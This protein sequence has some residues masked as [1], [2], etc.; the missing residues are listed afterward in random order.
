MAGVR[1][2]R[3]TKRFGEVLAVKDFTLDIRDGE[4]IILVGPSG[5]GKT[6]VLRCIAG[7]EQ[8]TSGEIYIDG[9]PVT[10][11]PA[12]SRDIAM[13]FQNYALYPHMDVYRNMAFCLKLR[14]IP[15][16]ERDRIVRQTAELLGIGALLGRKPSELSGGQ[17][18]RVA[19]GRAIVRDPKVFLFDEPL[20]NLDA[21]LRVAMRAELLDLHQRLKTTAI[22][23]T[24]DQMEAMTMGDR[25][26]VMNE[27]LV[28]QVASPQE[29]Y[30][31]PVNRFVAGFIG[32]PAMNLV[33]CH[34]EHR[35]GG[36][37]ATNKAMSL[38]IPPGKWA[39]LG[40]YVGKEVT[41]GLRPEHVSK[42]HVLPGSASQ[43]TFTAV[44]WVV[45]PLGPEKLVHIRQEGATLIARLDPHVS[46][47]P[48][49]TVTFAARMESAHLFDNETQRAIG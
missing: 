2:E 4:F 49:E 21:K 34:L 30:D 5:C 16:T 19:L 48:G 23:V 36:L 41:L 42:A 29:V 38:R 14:K 24:H 8:A 31:R 25:I 39:A 40:H 7:L 27:G 32:S 43:A 26:V 20:S 33:A 28:Q 22:Y 45:E 3:V 37:W 11:V 13:V 12:K 15:P 18:Q 17:R 1:L 10:R 47:R 44:V 35:D 6:T 46:I 9:R